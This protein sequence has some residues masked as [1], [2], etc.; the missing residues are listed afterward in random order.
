VTALL[1][2][3]RVVWE[4]ADWKPADIAELP[5]SLL[6]AEQLLADTGTCVIECGTLEQRL[7]C[8]LPPACVVVARSDQLA[9]H[10]PA[11]WQAIGQRVADP[12]GRGELVLVTGPSRTTDIEKVLILGVHGPKQLIVLLVQ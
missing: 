9:E 12:Q 8:Y 7:L 1:P 10:L 11:A 4:D 6:S 5:V 3:E 2:P